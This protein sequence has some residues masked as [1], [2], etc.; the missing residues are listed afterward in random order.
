MNYM[1]W[2]HSS[3]SKHMSA[4]TEEV[5]RTKR[6]SHWNATSRWRQ[7]LRGISLPG[8]LSMHQAREP[9]RVLH[10][11]WPKPA[12][13]RSIK[14]IGAFMFSVLT[15]C[16]AFKRLGSDQNLLAD[17]ANYKWAPVSPSHGGWH[18]SSEH[19]SFCFGPSSC[20]TSC[21]DQVT[22]LDQFTRF[23]YKAGFN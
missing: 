22:C 10:Q 13:Y 21:P 20:R 18:H 6:F 9:I 2:R 4:E 7:I 12:E 8:S 17:S 19:S 14:L 3:K 16:F 5:T 11:P 15:G 23:I 1:E